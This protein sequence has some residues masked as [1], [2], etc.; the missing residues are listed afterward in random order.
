[1]GKI[2]AKVKG[3][4]LRVARWVFYFVEFTFVPLSVQMGEEYRKAR[5]FEN[6]KR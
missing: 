5:H 1:M 2:T 4:L 6:D 3:G